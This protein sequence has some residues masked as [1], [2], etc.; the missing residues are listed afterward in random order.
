MMTVLPSMRNILKTLSSSGG[1]GARIDCG[2][3]PLPLVTVMLV[4]G[5]GRAYAEEMGIQFK[6]QYSKCGH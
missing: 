1:L 5:V 6:L 3:V 4:V 2:F